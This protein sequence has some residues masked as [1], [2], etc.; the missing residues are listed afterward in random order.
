MIQA[1]YIPKNINII[2]NIINTYKLTYIVPYIKIN[3]KQA[4]LPL[5]AWKVFDF[6]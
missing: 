3:M 2:I 6:S 4:K 5:L 1:K